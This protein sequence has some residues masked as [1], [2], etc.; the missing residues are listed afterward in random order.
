LCEAALI[1]AHTLHVKPKYLPAAVSG[2][3][4]EYGNRITEANFLIQNE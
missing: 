3:E 2:E 4:S 1:F